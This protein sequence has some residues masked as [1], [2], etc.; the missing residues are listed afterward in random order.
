MN[1]YRDA[2]TRVADFWAEVEAVMR[3][4]GLADLA[5]LVIYIDAVVV[6]GHH[7]VAAVVVDEAGD[8]HMLGLVH[9]FHAMCR[10]RYSLATEVIDPH[11]Q[12]G[13]R[14]GHTPAPAAGSP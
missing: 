5:I 7:I 1:D 2:A 3:E 4:K 14:P 12:A 6:D 8:K 9:V 11:R 13:V 10:C